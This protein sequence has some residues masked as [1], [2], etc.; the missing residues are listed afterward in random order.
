MPTK[1][2]IIARPRRAAFSPEVIELFR[3]LEATPACLRKD[4]NFRECE[5]LLH[6]LLGLSTEYHCSICSVLDRSLGP[7]RPPHYPA[8]KDW[9]RVRATRE[10][11]L[12]A[13]KTSVHDDEAA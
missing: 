6:E 9:Y 4:E 10:A 2:T 1:R 3:Q 13:V 5:A 12:R 7:C 8:S 11:L